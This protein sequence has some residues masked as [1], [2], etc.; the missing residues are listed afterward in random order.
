MD[1]EALER[2]FT[3][4]KRTLE[5][6]YLRHE[7]PIRQSGFSGGPERWH[8]ER[9]PIL[10]AID[11]DGDLLD[12]GCANGYLLE[13]LVEWGREG[14]RTVVPHGVD[15]SEKFIAL[16]EKRLP[17][18]A[19]NLWVANAWHWRPPRRFRFVYALL[20]SVPKELMGEYARR[21]FDRCVEPGG[22]LIAGHY[23]S[24][25][26]GESP[27]D[28]AALL[29]SRGMAIAGSAQGGYPAITRFAWTDKR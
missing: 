21:L 5:Q 15:L 18:F 17:R 28:V 11:E 7:D 2:W 10:A 3:E 9:S 4:K 8:S 16:A 14:G 20:D 22:R 1:P 19:S 23:G 24:R 12:V 27:I 29:A 25:S 6:E 26:R 13:C